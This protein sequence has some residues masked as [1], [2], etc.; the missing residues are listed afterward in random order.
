MASSFISGKFALDNQDKLAQHWNTT[1]QGNVDEFLELMKKPQHPEAEAVVEFAQQYVAD[2]FEGT[3]EHFFDT[4]KFMLDITTSCN[5]GEGEGCKPLEHICH[6]AQKAGE[7]HFQS[8]ICDAHH[9]EHVIIRD[10]CN[11]AIAKN[12]AD[13]EC[14]FQN[15][16]TNATGIVNGTSSRKL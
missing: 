3:C 7:C 2:T 12:L 9:Q 8:D 11:M 10:F 6:E 16:H 14:Y 15:A 4:Q 1:G 5:N 13:S